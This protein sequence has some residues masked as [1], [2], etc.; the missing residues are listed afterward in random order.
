M[1]GADGAP[2][3]ADRAWLLAGELAPLMDE[4]ER[5][6]IDLATACPTPPTPPSPRTGRGR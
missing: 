2:R 4:A 5:A 1:N 3:T 6:G